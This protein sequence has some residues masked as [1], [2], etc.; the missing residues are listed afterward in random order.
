MYCGYD[1][2]VYSEMRK[3]D[4]CNMDFAY[5]RILLLLWLRRVG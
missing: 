2:D 5:E 3:S 1:N 4:E